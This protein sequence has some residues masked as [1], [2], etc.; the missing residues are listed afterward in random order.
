MDLE[1]V[2][3]IWKNAAFTGAPI[4]SPWPS[5]IEVLQRNSAQ[6]RTAARLLLMGLMMGAPTASWIFCRKGKGGRSPDH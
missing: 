1:A 3:E 5:E 4:D 2:T 6:R